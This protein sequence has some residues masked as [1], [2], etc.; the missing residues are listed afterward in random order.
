MNKLLITLV[1]AL[2]CIYVGFP[3][4]EKLSNYSFIVVPKQF[5][6][7]FE[8]D[9]Y[10][11]NSLLKFLFN[12]NGF[13]A[14]FD[15]EL[16]DVRRCDG[17]RA[18]VKGDPGFVWCTVSI[19]IK[20]CDGNIIYTSEEGKSKLKEYNKMYIEALR[21]AFESI[22]V[23]FVQ[24][25]EVKLL[26]DVEDTS[27]TNQVE[28]VTSSENENTLQLPLAKYSNYSKNGKSYL[29]RKTMEGFSLYEETSQTNDGLQYTGKI[30]VVEGV[31]FFEDA[32]ENRYLA[33]FE[34]NGNLTVTTDNATIVYLKN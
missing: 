14:Y 21:R 4:Q 34:E 7:Q 12:K 10:Q 20:D 19:S 13:H 25:K 6:F 24:Q 23:L 18:E 1:I 9:Q 16:P 31:V 15:E 26:T 32:L 5:S 29:L 11:L 27:E 30:F 2:G 33:S 8:E 28:T 17:L 22:E 3:Q